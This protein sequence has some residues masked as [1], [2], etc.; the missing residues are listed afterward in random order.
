M[1]SE[2]IYLSSNEK[3]NSTLCS[4][5]DCYLAGNFYNSQDASNQMKASFRKKRPTVD[6]TTINWPLTPTTFLVSDY[7]E[8][9]DF[10]KKIGNS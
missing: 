4:S 8:Q 10:N 6:S 2:P 9:Q 1:A 7:D 3:E 5:L